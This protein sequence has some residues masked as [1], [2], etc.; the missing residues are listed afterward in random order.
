MRA[1]TH[2]V[3]LAL[4]DALLL[5]GPL[6]ATRASELIGEPPNTCSFHLRQLAKYGF[7]EE[8]GGGPGRNRPWRLTAFAMHFT[9]VHEDTAARLAA[10]SLDRLLRERYFA[11]LQAFYASRSEY[12]SEWQA[13]TGGSQFLLHVS[14]DELRAVDKEIT[15]ILDRYRERISNPNLRAPHSLPVEVLLFAY[16]VRPPA[17]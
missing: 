10:R 8:A 17:A 16:P 11:R 14:P 2:P 4:L 15:A 13:V 6:T 12:P 1:I 7:V 3:R 9:D 5:E